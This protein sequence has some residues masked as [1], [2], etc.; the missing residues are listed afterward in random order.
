LKTFIKKNKYTSL[1]HKT[2]KTKHMNSLELFQNAQNANKKLLAILID[3]DT[4]FE[5]TK[6]ILENTTKSGADFIFVGGSLLHRGRMEDCVSFIKN[7]TQLPIII[8]PGSEMQIC[9]Q[10]DSILFLT[11]IS[12]RNPELLIG[13]HVLAAPF[14]YKS[15]LEVIPTGYL[16]VEG[17]KSTTASYI[18]HSFPIPS[19]KP[20]IA[21]ATAQAGE[22]LGLKVI[23]LDAGSGAQNPVPEKMIRMVKSNTKIPL[24]VGGG[25]RNPNEIKLAWEAGADIVVVGNVL[26]ENPEQ[27]NLS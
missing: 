5:K 23:Y 19:D 26:E 24:I 11:L 7:L 6:E 27:I 13:K 4:D 2:L 14:L 3:P 16:L 12:G 15:K 25:L 10:A 8:F 9:E 17:D 18:S 1:K 21:M 20:E 22:L